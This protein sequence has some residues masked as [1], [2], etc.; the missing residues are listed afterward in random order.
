MG[1]VHIIVVGRW[2]GDL[3]LWRED[4]LEVTIK[5]TREFEGVC[6]GESNLRQIE[7]W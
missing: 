4:A 6:Y 2:S 1:A 7:L 5:V 3:L